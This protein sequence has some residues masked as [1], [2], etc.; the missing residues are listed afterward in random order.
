MASES[1]ERIRGFFRLGDI[2]TGYFCEASHTI[3]VWDKRGI[4]NMGVTGKMK[5]WPSGAYVLDGTKWPDVL[6]GRLYPHI[7]VGEP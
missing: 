2:R 5:L 6:P 1:D 7:M 3:Y 4:H